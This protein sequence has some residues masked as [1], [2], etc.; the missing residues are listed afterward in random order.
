V[1]YGERSAGRADERDGRDLVDGALVA[2]VGIDD[3][4]ARHHDDGGADHDVDDHRDHH[5]DDHYDQY[6]AAADDHDDGAADD[7]RADDTGADGPAGR[8]GRIG[9][10]TTPR[11]RHQGTRRHR[12]L[13]DVLPDDQQGRVLPTR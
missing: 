13:D 5:R 2:D 9:D 10:G 4:R 12:S 11:P 7:R 8:H 6:D 3:D 1:R